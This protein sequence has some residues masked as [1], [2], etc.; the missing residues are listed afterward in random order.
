M[1]GADRDA[2]SSLAEPSFYARTTPQMRKAGGEALV[3][4]LWEWDYDM[5][6]Y[7]AESVAA[8][9]FAAMMKARPT[10]A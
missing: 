6:L 9:I 1:A 4:A 8:E 5:S 2:G 10:D 7:S 3:R